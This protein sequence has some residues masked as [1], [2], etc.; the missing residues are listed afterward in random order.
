MCSARCN[1]LLVRF[2]RS[3]PERELH[4]TR[5]PVVSMFMEDHAAYVDA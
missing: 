5:F 4:I 3:L 1:S 2:D